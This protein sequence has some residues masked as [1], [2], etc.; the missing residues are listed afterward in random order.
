M[1]DLEEDVTGQVAAV[2]GD[3]MGVIF[4]KLRHESYSQHIK[5]NDLTHAVL[6][7]NVAWMK[8]TKV[9][10]AYAFDRKHLSLFKEILV[11]NTA[12]E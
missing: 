3:G 9:W 8:N 12:E 1:L 4:R 5:H 10:T 7:Y 6:S 11:I 2:I